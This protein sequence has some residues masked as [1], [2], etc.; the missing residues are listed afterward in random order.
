MRAAWEWVKAWWLVMSWPL[1]LLAV[2]VVAGLVLWLAGGLQSAISH[3]R[4]AWTD[5][6][7]A[8]L[9]ADNAAKQAE[10]DKAMTE[11][12]RLTQAVV[13]KDAELAAKQQEID[14]LTDKAREQDAKLEDTRRAYE[15]ARRGRAGR[16][17]TNRD[18]LDKRLRDLFETAPQ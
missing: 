15:A 18:D 16:P 9:E 10:L 17:V 12:V 5:H 13:D 1:R 7:V 6:K 8:A 4:D 2:A 3:A 14:A 11:N